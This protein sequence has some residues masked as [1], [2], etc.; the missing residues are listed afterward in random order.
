MTCVFL[1][2]FDLYGSLVDVQPQMFWKR[3]LQTSLF[4]QG[5]MVNLCLEICTDSN[6]FS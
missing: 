5:R 6:P 2:K 4:N 1:I 3:Y